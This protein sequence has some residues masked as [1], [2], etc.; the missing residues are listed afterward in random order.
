MANNT[1]IKGKRMIFKQQQALFSVAALTTLRLF[2]ASVLFAWDGIA[3]KQVFSM[4][5]FTTQNGES[6]PELNVGWEA[7]GEL[8]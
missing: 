3:E 8:E 4:Q 2:P 6:I 1:S 5:D 7:Y